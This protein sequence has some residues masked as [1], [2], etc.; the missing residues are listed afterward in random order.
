VTSHKDS[1]IKES[2]NNSIIRLPKAVASTAPPAEGMLSCQSQQLMNNNNTCTPSN[3]SGSNTGRG[4]S[5]MNLQSA[6]PPA[7]QLKRLFTEYHFGQQI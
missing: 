3:V 5:N 1:P 4:D 2:F 7:L 6:H